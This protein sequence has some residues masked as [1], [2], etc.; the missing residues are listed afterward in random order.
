MAITAPLFVHTHGGT[1]VLQQ[2]HSVLATEVLKLHLLEMW[3]EIDPLAFGV[4]ALLCLVQ[5]FHQDV[6]DDFIVVGNSLLLDAV[7]SYLQ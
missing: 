3:I 4:I 7:P 2:G 5:I 1:Q 6:W